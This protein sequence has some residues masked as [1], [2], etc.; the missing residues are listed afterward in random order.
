MCMVI[1]QI[2]KNSKIYM[3]KPYIKVGYNIS[4]QFVFN[5]W[6]GFATYEEVLEIGNRTIDTCLAERAQRVLF[7][8]R[9]ME[10]L[11]EPSRNYISNVFTEKMT[12]IGVKYAATVLPEDV[13]AIQSMEDIKDRLSEEKNVKVKYFTSTTKAVSWLRSTM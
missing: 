3:N 11:D 12:K 10:V 9:Y 1:S 13:F 2:L 6:S 5:L 7:D 8:S 4:N